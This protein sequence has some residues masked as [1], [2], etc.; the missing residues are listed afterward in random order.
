MVISKI[1]EFAESG[2]LQAKNNLDVAYMTSGGMEYN[3]QQTVYWFFRA[4]S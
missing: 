2:V 3:E 4:S 1:K